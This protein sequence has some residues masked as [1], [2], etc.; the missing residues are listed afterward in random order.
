M[1]LFQKNPHSDRQH[2]PLYSVGLNKTILIIG[3]GNVGKE[4][5]L[6][7][8]NVGFTC[9]DAFATAHEFDDWIE[10]KDLKCLMTMK[11]LGDSRVILCKPTTFMNHSGEAAQKIAHFY[12][13]H[14]EQVVAVHDELA[15]K[16]GQIRTRTGGSDAGNN[17]IKSLIAHIGAD[18][19]RVRIGIDGDRPE[20]MDSADY[21]LA[22]F[23][24][25]EQE[26]LPSLTREVTSILTEYVFSGQFPHDTRNFLI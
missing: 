14:R 11:T 1:A 25:K 24:Q 17:G 13:I 7:R 20:Q 9:V 15:I 4:Y 21:V 23:S 8:H 26:H 5:E 2:Q 10:K 22:K 12:K 6:T 18:F 19:G 3:L 16:F